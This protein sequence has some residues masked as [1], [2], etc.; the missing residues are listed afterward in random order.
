[1]G[2]Y[3]CAVVAVFMINDRYSINFF[4]W[5]SDAKKLFTDQ[6]VPKRM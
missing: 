2:L 1:M 3:Y 6:L 4:E 5:G